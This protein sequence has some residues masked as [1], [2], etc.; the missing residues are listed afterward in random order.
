MNKGDLGEN[1]TIYVKL[2]C[3]DKT[4]LSGKTIHIKLT[5]N[6]NNV[7]YDESVETQATGVAIVKLNNLGAGEYK[8]D[9]SFDGDEIYT[10]CSISQNVTIKEGE[11]KDE[12]ANSTLIQQTIADSQG[13]SSQ[14]SSAPASSSSQSSSSQ[15]SSSDSSSSSSADSSSNYYDENGKEVLPEYDADGKQIN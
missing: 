10:G 5:D 7:V 15:S 1:S 12:L 8:L 11:V 13:T 9:A 6:K 4:S 3:G 2:T 14:S